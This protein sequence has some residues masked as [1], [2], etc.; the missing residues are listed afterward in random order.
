MTKVRKTDN[1]VDFI[2]IKRKWS[3]V[4]TTLVIAVIVGFGGWIWTA[5][6]SPMIKTPTMQLDEVQAEVK[7]KVDKTEYDKQCS[8]TQAQIDKK[9]DKEQYYVSHNSLKDFIK[10]QNA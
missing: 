6:I 9:L 7:K 5:F 1:P 4:T 3:K 2:A 10:E 8:I